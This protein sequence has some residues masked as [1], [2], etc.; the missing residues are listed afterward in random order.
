MRSQEQK[1]VFYPCCDRLGG[2]LD[3]LLENDPQR[4]SPEKEYMPLATVISKF[5]A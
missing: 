3:Q 1:L 2:I 5:D 4:G